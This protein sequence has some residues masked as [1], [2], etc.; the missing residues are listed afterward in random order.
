MQKLAVF[1]PPEGIEEPTD[2]NCFHDPSSHIRAKANYNKRQGRKG[3]AYRCNGG[4]R[5]DSIRTVSV[6]CPAHC[7]GCPREQVINRHGVSW[8]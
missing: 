5:R 3:D 4:T 1:L 7:K 6:E 8:S 2:S